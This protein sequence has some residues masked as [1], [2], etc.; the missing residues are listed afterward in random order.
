MLLY[1]SHVME[2]GLLDLTLE[3]NGNMFNKWVCEANCGSKKNEAYCDLNDQRLGSP[4]TCNKIRWCSLP[5]QT[6][7]KVEK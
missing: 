4:I 1:M 7:Q 3:L 5:P 6:Q 2:K